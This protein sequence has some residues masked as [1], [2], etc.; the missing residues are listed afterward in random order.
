MQHAGQGP[1]VQRNQDTEKQQEK[2]VSDAEPEPERDDG[3]DC[4]GED[5]AKGEANFLCHALLH[6]SFRCP[7]RSISAA[8]SSSSRCPAPRALLAEPEP[9]GSMPI[10]CFSA[11]SCASALTPPTP[12]SSCLK[13]R[14]SVSPV[15]SSSIS[16]AALIWRSFV[17]MR[18]SI[19]ENASK[20]LFSDSD[21]IVSWMRCCACARRWRAT[22]RFFLRFASSILSLRSRSWFLSLSESALWASHVC[23]SCC[24]CWRCSP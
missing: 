17:S 6:E 1:E 7:G 13:S 9:A 20:A 19:R 16:A 4:G 15:N 14:C 24:P 8:I 11:R 22:S 5:G 2:D 23:S 18:S 3:E 12:R 10:F 21:D